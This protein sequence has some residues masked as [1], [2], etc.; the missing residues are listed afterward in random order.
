LLERFLSRALQARETEAR[1]Q[2]ALKVLLALT[3]LERNVR[4][5]VLSAEDIERKLDGT[6]GIEEVREALA[7]LS[8]GDVRLTT[9]VE[10]EANPA[11]ELAHER[12]IPA[13]RRLAGKE[14][15]AADRASQLLDQRV[16]EWLGNQQSR[17][18]L[19]TWREWRLIQGQSP[20]LVW[21]VNKVHKEALL[22]KS[23]QYWRLRVGTAS[24]V[25]LL[26][27]FSIAWWYSPWGQIWQVK[28]DL[29]S[30][31]G[32]MDSN[33]SAVVASAWCQAGECEQALQIAEGIR[34]GEPDAKARALSGVAEA[35]AKLGD[36]TKAAELIDE[37]RQNAEGIHE[38]MAKAG[39]LSGVAEA[40]AK[41]GDTTK[42]AALIEEVLRI[43]RGIDDSSEDKSIAL[44]RVAE[45]VAEVG[46][47]TRNAVLI[48]QARQIA[49]GIWIGEPYAKARALSGV[50]EAAAKQ[51]NWYQARKMAELAT[52]DDGRA[53]ILA[54]ILTVWAEN[55]NSALLKIE[56]KDE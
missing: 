6:V 25:A 13:L 37:V 56:P 39:V 41:L 16:N 35:A 32:R 36:S 22:A 49:E 27:V 9:P 12:L 24:L 21:G 17:R 14:L 4:A 33:S 42:A 38:P 26:F 29:E 54:A 45:A 53:R 8:R 20:F 43:A 11:Y 3:D 46:A 50:A 10:R 51:G 34:I 7:W 28:R 30:L 5:G 19:L 2:A 47:E 15:S 18:Y 44:S 52:T 40:V 31:Q 55:R 1:R 23:Q 48:E